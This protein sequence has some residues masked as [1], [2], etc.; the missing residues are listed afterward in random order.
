MKS[1]KEYLTE[2]KRVY[3]FKI[4]VAG[5]CPKDASAKIKEALTTYKVESCSA[6][7]S[8][9]ITEKQVDFPQLENVGVTIFDVTLSY[10]ATNVQVR[11]AVADKL[12]VVPAKIRVRNMQEEEELA[13]NHEHDEKTG[14]AF[15][16]KTEIEFAPGGQEMVGDNRRLAFLKELSKEPKHN[17]E[18]TG[19]NDKLF[20]K[21]GKEKPQAE[22]STITE[23]SASPIGTKPNKIP[24]PLGGK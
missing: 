1:Y 20:P 22:Q 13:I 7:K 15:L 6:G 16:N 18:Y 2:S 14:E 11:E 4:K 5:E 9:P 19:V 8:T 24:R 23:K 10:P 17:T 12:S 3:E 21:A